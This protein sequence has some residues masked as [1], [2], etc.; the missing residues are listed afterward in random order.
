[1]IKVT[2]TSIQ[3]RGVKN[4]DSTSA[5]LLKIACGI[6]SPMSKITRV[7]TTKPTVP[8]AESDTIIENIELIATLAIRIEHNRRLA[9]LLRG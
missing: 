7:E 9:L 6:I 3:R 8:P 5:Y 1:M 4:H 2:V